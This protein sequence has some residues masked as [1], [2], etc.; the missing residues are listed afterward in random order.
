MAGGNSKRMNSTIP[1]VL[2]KINNEPMIIK[3]IKE[4][5]K[6]DLNKILIVVGQHEEIIKQTINNFKLNFEI[7][8]I[9]QQPQLGTGHAIMCCMDYL[10]KLDPESSICILSGDCPLITSQT[11]NNFFD[12]C[13][14]KIGITDLKDPTGYGRVVTNNG[15]F[16]DIIEQKDCTDE[17]KSIKIVNTGI[18]MIKN[19]LLLKYVP[20]IDNFNNQ[21]EYYLTSL[22]KYMDNIITFFTFNKEIQ[23]EMF[24]INTQED[25]N[26]LNT[27]ISKQWEY[28]PP[29]FY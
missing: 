12:N 9:K 18:Y 19:K 13:D 7:L 17:Q 6:L 11:I 2:I 4:C 22:F 1:K 24:G 20:F 16:V 23:H 27:F 3:I 5:L 21:N 14:V 29:W 28:D 25:L 26:K 8:F 15:M 10:K